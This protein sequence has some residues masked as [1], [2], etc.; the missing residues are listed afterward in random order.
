MS[1][2]TIASA[3]NALEDLL[4]VSPQVEAAV[5]TS[6]D[7]AVIAY[8]P[9]MPE[10]AV[11]LFTQSTQNIITAADQSRSDL[12]REPVVQIEIATAEGHIFIVSDKNHT[13]SAVTAPDPTVG[14]VF[15]DLKT[16]LRTIKNIVSIE[17]KNSSPIV[18]PIVDSEQ[19]TLS[20]VTDNSSVPKI[21]T[22]RWRRRRS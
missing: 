6:Q 4:E 19:A 5:I 21:K 1:E 11:K 14:L 3:F 22:G 8:L 2:P 12:G 18:V 16:V 9:S 10:H 13:I 15:Y 20:S 7:G 17:Q